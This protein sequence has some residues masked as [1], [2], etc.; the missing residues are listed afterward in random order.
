MCGAF[1]PCVIR[2][3]QLANC[4]QPTTSTVNLRINELLNYRQIP[5]GTASNCRSSD[6]AAFSSGT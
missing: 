2:Y 6:G 1:R 4:G 5:Q 3:C